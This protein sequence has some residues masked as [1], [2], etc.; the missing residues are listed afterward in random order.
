MTS[1]GY[2]VKNCPSYFQGGCYGCDNLCQNILNCVVKQ[3][4][5]E[6]KDMASDRDYYAYD[7]AK[8]V[9]QL[10]DIEEINK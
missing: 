8:E 10:F 9:L 4:V 1:N 5:E 6:C 7:F 2:I 3:V